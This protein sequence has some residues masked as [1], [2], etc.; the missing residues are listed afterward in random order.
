MLREDVKQWEKQSSAQAEK[1]FFITL[2][3]IQG[4]L[5]GSNRLPGA[6]LIDCLVFGRSA[7]RRAAGANQA[8]SNGLSFTKWVQ[9][10][11]KEVRDSDSKV[12]GH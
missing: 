12:C 3:Y 2:I 10:P 1:S 6:S 9:L 11:L 5:H 8:S 4:G 7:G